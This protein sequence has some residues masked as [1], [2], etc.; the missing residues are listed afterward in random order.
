RGIDFATG[1]ES[2]D[3]TD[4][5]PSSQLFEDDSL[6]TFVVP[7]VNLTPNREVVSATMPMFNLKGSGLSPI[8]KRTQCHYQKKT[9]HEIFPRRQSTAG[10]RIVWVYPS[11]TVKDCVS[12]PCLPSWRQIDVAMPDFRRAKRKRYVSYFTLRR[13]VQKKCNPSRR[14]HGGTSLIKFAF[15]P[16]LSAAIKKIEMRGY[17]R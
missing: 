4:E 7:L 3:R 14:A 2:V 8:Q 17:S 13:F 9:L 11:T 6:K 1:R 10:G 16:S 15:N 12:V 5:I